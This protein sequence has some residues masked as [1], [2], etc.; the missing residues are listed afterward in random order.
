MTTIDGSPSPLARRSGDRPVGRHSRAKGVVVTEVSAR[1]GPGRVGTIEA[2]TKGI[3]NSNYLVNLGDERAEERLPGPDT[4]L[5]G[6]DR[7]NE[8][9]VDRLAA[10]IGVGPE[11]VLVDDATD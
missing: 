4:E 9:E 11:I 1:L 6:L 3:N 5:L 7:G 2:L 8:V 10:A